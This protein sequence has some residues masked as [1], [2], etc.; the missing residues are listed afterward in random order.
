MTTLRWLPYTLLGILGLGSALGI[1]VGLSEAPSNHSVSGGQVPAN[2]SA[3]SAAWQ[4]LAIGPPLPP[5]YRTSA[6][7]YVAEVLAADIDESWLMLPSDRILSTA[8]AVPSVVL[9]FRYA[10]SRN[11]VVADVVLWGNRWLGVDGTT[12]QVTARL[13][14]DLLALRPPRSFYRY[15][16]QPIHQPAL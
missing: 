10:A 4:P 13:L 6:G 15:L 12:R 1:G 16:G 7:S 2:P 5:P 14:A 11:R 8:A 9:T 3:V